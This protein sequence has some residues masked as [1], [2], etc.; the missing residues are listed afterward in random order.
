[1]NSGNDGST[2]AYVLEGVPI[3]ATTAVPLASQPDLRI[4]AETSG[5]NAIVVT[6]QADLDLAARDVALSAF[7]HAGQKCS[8]ASLVITVGSVSR[9]R[10]FNAQLADGSPR[11]PVDQR[12]YD[13]ETLLS[14]EVGFKSTFMDGRAR[15]NGAAFY[16]DYDDYQAF[17]FVQSSG[18]VTNLN[19]E[20]TGVELDLTLNPVDG[21]DIMF[22]ASYFDAVVEDLGLAA[23]DP[24]VPPLLKD[25]DGEEGDWVKLL[26]RRQEFIAVGT[27][28]ER[29]GSA[30]VGVIQPK[31]VF[32]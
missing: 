16:Y 31:I 21:L 7:G 8:A 20:T 10:R 6:P 3:L 2:Y 32:T 19:A 17:V 30:G 18:T 4:L 9:S 12:S 13:P 23:S 15:L 24:S 1:M 22:G 27:V 5:K 29:I 25:V 28:V 26:N 11:L 14:Y